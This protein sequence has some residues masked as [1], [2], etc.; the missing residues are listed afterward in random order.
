MINFNKEVDSFML[1]DWMGWIP[2]LVISGKCLKTIAR[3][4]PSLIGNLRAFSRCASKTLQVIGPR[5]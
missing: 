5:A 2:A 1:T 3:F 4:D